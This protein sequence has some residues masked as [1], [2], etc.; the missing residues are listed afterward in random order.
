MGLSSWVGGCAFSWRIIPTAFRIKVP[1]ES[2]NYQFTLPPRYNACTMHKLVWQDSFGRKA[3]RAWLV[4]P[5][6]TTR[7]QKNS[8]NMEFIMQL[9]RD[10]AHP[11]P[12][13]GFTQ[14]IPVLLTL[15]LNGHD[16]VMSREFS[17]ALT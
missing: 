3:C 6:Q 17:H 8:H 2:W 12:R 1:L 9:P 4:N 5:A 7:Q 13:G 14:V 15:P 16:R 11:V 10:K